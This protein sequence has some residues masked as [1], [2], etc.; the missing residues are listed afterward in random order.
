MWR[1]RATYFWKDLDKGYNFALELISI[2]GLHKKLWVSKVAKILIFEISKFPT[3][4]SWKKWHLVATPMA[5]HREYYKGEGDGFPQIRAVWVLWIH[6]CPWFVHAPKMFQL[7]TNQLVVWFVH[8]HMNNWPT[9]HSSYSP[10]QSSNT[11]FLP[12]KCY[13]RKNIL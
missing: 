1:W 8:I 3:W 12:S 11:P 5:S 9:C 10:S 6:V 2:E 7:C 4:R 13:E